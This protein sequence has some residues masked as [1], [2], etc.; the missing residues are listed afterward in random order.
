LVHRQ[1]PS[2][3]GG[4]GILQIIDRLGPQ[5][6][7]AIARIRALSRQNI[8]TLVNRLEALGYVAL[9]ANPAH[10]RSQLVCLTDAGGT[11]L[12]TAR[13]RELNSWELLLPQLPEARLLPITR[14]LRRLRLLLA[15]NEL[16]PDERAVGP[17]ARKRARAL[18]KHARRRRLAS[19]TVEPLATPAPGQTDE[20]D[21]PVNLL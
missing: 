14:L 8:Q 3:A 12:S 20:G 13:K 5:T 19:A 11:L 9:A 6:V 21:F 17:S 1:D 16:S 7:P 4:C 15:G 18:R 2:P 10:K